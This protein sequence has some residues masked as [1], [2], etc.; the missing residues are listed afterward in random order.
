MVH[1]IYKRFIKKDANQQH[2]VLVSRII[3]V[4]LMICSAFVA[5]NMQSISKAWEFI[6][7]MG[8]GIGL[9]LILRWF[10]WRINAWTEISAL[11][12]SIIITIVLEIIAWNQTISA[13][14]EYTLFDKSPILFGVTIQVHHKLMIIVPVAVIVWIIVTFITKPESEK[15]LTTFYQKVQPGGWWGSYAK[16]ATLQPVTQGFFFNWIAGIGLIY[17]LNFAIGNWMFGNTGYAISLFFISGIGFW[18][19]W[20]NLLGKIDS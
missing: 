12:T 16:G 20:N 3:T 15:T 1:D 9:V 18:W 17:G 11:L 5:I 10:W 6:F 8:A 4:I 7:S 19:L 14:L 2:Y 13:G